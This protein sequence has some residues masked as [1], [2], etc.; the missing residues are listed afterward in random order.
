MESIVGLNKWVIL[1]VGPAP[2]ADYP[3]GCAL[4]MVKR[5]ILD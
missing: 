4:M 2:G 1:T 5:I 3:G